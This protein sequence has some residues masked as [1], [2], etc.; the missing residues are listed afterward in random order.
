MFV[1]IYVYV[2]VC[3]YIYV[4]VCVCVHIYILLRPKG[5]SKYLVQNFSTS[6]IHTGLRN[7]KIPVLIFAIVYANG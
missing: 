2:H 5:W 6:R 7:N 4:C 3:V 1:Y